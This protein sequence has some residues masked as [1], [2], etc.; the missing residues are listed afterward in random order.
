MVKLSL[1]L[2]IVQTIISGFIFASIMALFGFIW[3]E[4]FNTWQFIFNGTFFGIFMGILLPVITKITTDRVLKKTIIELNKDEELVYEGA[5]TLKSN[6]SAGGKLVLT[7][8][9]L[10]FKPHKLNSKKM[11]VEIHLKEVTK[12]GKQNSLRFI[13]NILI[14]QKA[15]EEFKFFVAENERDVWVSKLTEQTTKAF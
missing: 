12:V 3:G 4:K 2:M 15:D 8:K 1:K 7:T 9:R 5:S 14:I 10:A 6:F 13:H 11:F